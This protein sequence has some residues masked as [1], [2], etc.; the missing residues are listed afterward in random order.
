MKVKGARHGGSG[1]QTEVTMFNKKFSFRKKRGESRDEPDHD[2]IFPSDPS[3]DTLAVPGAS[4]S[5]DIAAPRRDSSPSS[6]SLRSSLLDRKRTSSSTFISQTVG[7]GDRDGDTADK[8]PLGLKVIHRPSKDRTVDIVFVHGLGGSSRRTWSKDHNLDFF[9]PLKFLPFEPGISEARI[10]T[11]GY[12]SNFRSGSRRNK[13][14]LLDFA[15]NLLFDLKYAQDDSMGQLED[16]GM[17]ERPIVFVVHSMGGLIVKEAYMQGQNDPK[18]EA[19]IKSVSAIVFL[20][21]PHRGTNL[22][23]TLNR[24]LQ[25]S[26]VSNPM[27][28]IAELAAGSQTLQKLN[29]Q[30]RHIA[31]KLEIVSFYETR[32]T[33]V[34]SKTQI[35][36]LEKD[37]AVLGYPGEVS[38]PLDADHH[39]VCK[40]ASRVDPRYVTVRNVLKNLIRKGMPSDQSQTTTG[41][42]SKSTFEQL[43]SVPES[44]ERDYSVFRDRWT[45]GTCSWILDHP[46]FV[47]WLEDTQSDPRVLW[48]QGNAASGKSVLSSFV[49]DHL[50]QLGLPCQYFFVRFEDKKKRALN[51]ILRSLACQ[52][53]NTTPAYAHQLRQLETAGADLKSQDYRNLWQWLYKQSLFHLPVS[54][55][56]FWVLDGID[57]SDSPRSLLN[58]L[59]ELR[60]INIPIRILIVSRK[61][62]DIAMSFQ[63][64]SDQ[65]KIET[66]TTEGNHD[67]FHRYISRE[68]HLAGDNSYREGIIAEVLKRAQGNF[69]WVHLAVQRINKCHTKVDV[70][71]ALND[72]PPGMEALYNRMA[73]SV[74]TEPH[75]D[76]PTLGE[77]I[78]GWA[79][80]VQRPLSVEELSDALD[81]DGVLE[82][83]RTIGDLCGGFVVVDHEGKVALIHETAREYLSRG[84]QQGVPLVME[85]KLIHNKLFTRCITRLMDK[86][87]RAHI[88]QDRQP[89]L[90]DYATSAWVFHLSHGSATSRENLEILMKFFQG[91][92]VL[93][94]IQ[95]AA[96]GKQLRSLVTASRRLTDIVER[97]R[98]FNDEESLLHRQAIETLTRW[99]TDLVK[100]VGKFG[101]SL[102]Q[103]PDAIYKLIPP[104][105]PEDSAIYQQFG[106]KESK[107]LRISGLTRGTWDDC[108][109]RLS[110]EPGAVASAVHASGSRIAVL[111]N[112]QKVG[113]IFVYN[114]VTWEE[115]RRIAHPERVSRIRVDAAGATLVSYGYKTT[116]LWSLSSGEC[117]KTVANPAGRPRPH[118]I[119]FLEKNKTV[120]IGSE[121]RCA[122]SVKVDGDSTEWETRARIEEEAPEYGVLNAP[123]CSALSPDGEMIAFGYRGHPVTVWQ[124]GSEE[125]VGRCNMTPDGTAVTNQ[126]NTFGEITQLTWH[127]FS[128]EVLGL[129]REGLLFKW[130]PY[131]DEASAKVQAGAHFLAVSLDGSLVATGDTRGTVKVYTTADFSLLYQLSSPDP[132]LDI[133]FSTDSRRLYDT[134]GAYGNVWEPNALVRLAES[135]EL[136]D[137]SSDAWGEND[138]LAKQSPQTAQHFPGVDNVVAISG[139]PNGP[140]YCYGTEDGVAV[141]GE[142]GRGTVAELGRSASFMSVEHMAWSED[143]KLVALA[144]LSRRIAVMS[145]AKTDQAGPTWRVNHDFHLT[146][147]SQDGFTQLLFQPN[148]HRLLAVSPTALFVVDIESRAVQVSK[149]PDGA[150][151]MRFMCHPTKPDYLLA[152]GNTKGHVLT[153]DGLRQVAKHTYFP[154]RLNR[155][156]TLSASS[157]SYRPGSSGPAEETLGRLISCPGSPDILLEVSRLADTGR[158]GRQYLLF[159]ADDIELDPEKNHGATD[160]TGAAES[161]NNLPYTTLSA[162]IACRIREPLAILSRRR[163][164]FLDVD[165]W[166]CTWRI[167]A[168]PQAPGRPSGGRGSESGSRGIEAHYFLPGDWV[169]ANEAPLCTV[170]PDGTLL[171]TR[172]GEVGA[173]QCAKIR[174]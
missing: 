13:M 161:C 112:R 106:L 120:L 96:R 85:P 62:H 52:L 174:R 80:Y 14:S 150:P 117:V 5:T 144:D 37:S 113:H 102:L 105:C 18:Y 3:A 75:S 47:E 33:T 20:S 137:H 151:R 66:V 93:T 83:H 27:Q 122:R 49:I 69:L 17:G 61:T 168:L 68:M 118:S 162:E 82:I 100:L 124:L 116:K 164:V 135:S 8:D 73:N 131:D 43:L 58:L 2:R 36:V 6:N 165:R 15:K 1:P 142:V 97:L 60:S 152:F 99:A 35:M 154:P 89:A 48:I 41:K 126:E 51:T 173:V 72:L 40:Y 42:T 109:A 45:P 44:P 91:P 101:T 28:Y 108:L 54:Y 92:P 104:F 95:A 133:A 19:I 155:V 26:F 159:E 78:L 170:M 34:F 46:A 138:S 153:W 166:I 55:P 158:P 146:L 76:N 128:G 50:V 129:H 143:G 79:T 123:T 136:T 145:I 141:L 11:F 21:T 77:R 98:R 114:S 74:Q 56:I 59:S 139:Q 4:N 10:S 94:W 22:A 67:D 39:G 121:D 149:I 12:N 65:L 29:E 157:P 103:K 169:T 25:V 148:G 63:Q 53:A 163:L 64:L 107:A 119:V 31:P 130:D 70:S 81:D 172:N 132:V 167:S 134:R 111:A 23:E 125:L 7:Y 24:I 87:L 156:A 16:L 38:M 147:P 9:W 171:C 140:L 90:L 30:F 71:N 84:N 127:P 115:E 57:E 88:N 110:L 32:P 160:E 86:T